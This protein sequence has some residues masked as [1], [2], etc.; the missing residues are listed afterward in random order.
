MNDRISPIR[1]TIQ[2]PFLLSFSHLGLSREEQGFKL[3]LGCEIVI[4]TPGRLIDVLENHY[5][6]LNR[7]TYIVLD[8]ADR[9]IDMG[10]EPDV[11]KVSEGIASAKITCR[12]L[13]LS[14]FVRLLLY[15][16]N[17]HSFIYSFIC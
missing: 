5:L 13:G 3:R 11:Q 4:A 1:C 15:L 12:F 9:M 16:K 8:E 14:G 17:R 7:C 6:V 10:F 2:P